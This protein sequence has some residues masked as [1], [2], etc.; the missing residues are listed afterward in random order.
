MPSGKTH[1]IVGAVSLI[2]FN[3]FY[4]NYIV[5]GWN[6]YLILPVWYIYSLLP[7]LDSYTGMLRAKTI[8]IIFFCLA[9][10]PLIYIYFNRNAAILLIYF[11]II[12]FVGL[13]IFGLR[14]R[15]PLHKPWFL[16]I[17]SLP[18]WYFSFYLVASALI[19]SFSHII[20][21]YFVSGIKHGFME[22][23]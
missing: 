19:A 6:I 13:V 18:L 8:W 17:A 11:S 7:D 9:V 15:G 4:G 21:D 16:I 2:I 3:L 1:L 22:G 10:S 14:H 5:E 20:A 12:G 23:K